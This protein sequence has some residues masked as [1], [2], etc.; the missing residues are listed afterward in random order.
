MCLVWYFDV[1]LVTFFVIKIQNHQQTILE[2][3]DQVFINSTFT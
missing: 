1:E 3:I 2:G